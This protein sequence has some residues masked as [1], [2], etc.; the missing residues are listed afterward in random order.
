MSIKKRVASGTV[1]YKLVEEVC[2]ILLVKSTSGGNW[3]FP[4]GGLEPELTKRENALKETYEEAGVI[5]VP[6]EKL[7]EYTYYKAGVEQEVHMYE[8]RVTLE[9][10]EYPEGEMRDRK[11]IKLS[12]AF[13]T[14]ST[15][16]QFLLGPLLERYSV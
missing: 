14:L 4:K 12:D 9:L 7:G 1:P 13:D 11:W 16:H 3:V 15:D 2:H 6:G 10:E 8:M 5:G